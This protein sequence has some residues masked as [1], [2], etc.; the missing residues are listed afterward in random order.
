MFKGT[1]KF[2]IARYK[3]FM[4]QAKRSIRIGNVSHVAG[5]RFGNLY[6]VSHPSKE[7]SAR[8]SLLTGM[9]DL[10]N[11]WQEQAT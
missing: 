2:N 6:S 4:P 7:L 11:P 3:Y 9:Q 8:V 10:E 1:I 5:S